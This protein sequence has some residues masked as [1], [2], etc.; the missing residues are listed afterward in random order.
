MIYIKSILNRLIQ[1]FLIR[2]RQLDDMESCYSY[3]SLPPLKRLPLTRES[4]ASDQCQ[5]FSFARTSLVFAV[6][7]DNLFFLITESRYLAMSSRVERVMANQNRSTV[8][9]QIVVNR[10]STT[11]HFFRLLCFTLVNTQKHCVNIAASPL[12]KV[13]TR[14]QKESEKSVNR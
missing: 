13:H 2:T 5:L 7:V 8:R 3:Y 4:I 12:C 11:I 10:H 6:C 1:L 9:M 14:I